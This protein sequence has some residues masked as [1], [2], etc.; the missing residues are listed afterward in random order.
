[1]KKYAEVDTS[2]FPEVRITFT[3]EKANDENFEQYLQESRQTYD[4][5]E[6]L[7]MIFD[8]SN[9]TVPGIKYQK[10]QADWLKENE[11]LMKTYC[12]GTAYVIPNP[13]IRTVLKGIFAFQSQPVPYKVTASVEEAQQWIAGLNK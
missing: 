1:M 11:D 2:N 9:A 6:G 7:A 3:G 10:Q 8:A 13:I 4:R 5:A 12:K